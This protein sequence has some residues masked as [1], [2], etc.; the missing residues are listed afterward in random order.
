MMVYKITEK[1]ET[2]CQEY[3]VVQAED[4]DQAW[5]VVKDM[6][7]NLRKYYNITEIKGPLIDYHLA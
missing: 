1:K 6:M 3:A 5:E 4:E 2:I 7:L